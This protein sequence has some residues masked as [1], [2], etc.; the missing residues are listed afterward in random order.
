M[1][2]FNI[3]WNGWSGCNDDS[4]SI[5]MQCF[6]TTDQYMQTLQAHQNARHQPLSNELRNLQTHM[7]SQGND[8]VHH[9]GFGSHHYSNAVTP[10]RPP[11]AN[12]K[13]VTSFHSINANLILHQ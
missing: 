10:G 12:G 11:L 8:P 9:N 1:F 6:A 13:N 2:N 3:G 7:L 5:N 4:N